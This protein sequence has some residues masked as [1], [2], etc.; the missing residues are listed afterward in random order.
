M[1]I[2]EFEFMRYRI[3]NKCLCNKSVV[4]Y[5]ILN[6]LLFGLLGTITVGPRWADHDIGPF[7]IVQNSTPNSN[8][9][10]L[11]LDVEF[12]QKTL[13]GSHPSFSPIEASKGHVL[14]S[15]KHSHSNLNV[16]SDIGIFDLKRP[17]GEFCTSFF[18]PPSFEFICFAKYAPSSFMIKDTFTLSHHLGF[19]A[20]ES[21]PSLNAPIFSFS[22]FCFSTIFRECCGHL[23]CK[24]ERLLI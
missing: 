12:N 23:V 4:R 2:M 7:N 21:K 6:G 10:F 13:V 14:S 1:H 20:S 15:R 11:T 8:P 17:H 9:R 24:G 19:A 5:F 22:S 3:W 18:V 16:S